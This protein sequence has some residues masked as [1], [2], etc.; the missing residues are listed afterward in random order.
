MKLRWVRKCPVSEKG[1]VRNN[2]KV[3]V[4][5]VRCVKLTGSLVHIDMDDESSDNASVE[6]QS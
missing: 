3:Q 4:D 1:G 2:V 6:L 5:L